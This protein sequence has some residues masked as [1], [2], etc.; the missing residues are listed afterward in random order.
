MQHYLVVIGTILVCVVA[1]VVNY[2]LSIENSPSEEVGQPVAESRV[3]ITNPHT[4]SDGDGLLNWE[5]DLHG[6]SKRH[7]DSDG[8]GIA[9]GVEVNNGTDPTRIEVQQEPEH[10]QIIT[11]PLETYEFAQITQPV[12]LQDLMHSYTH[13]PQ[14]LADLVLDNPALSAQEV[15]YKEGLNQIATLFENTQVSSLLD[16]Q[17]MTAYAQGNSVD[18]FPIEELQQAYQVAARGYQSI[19]ENYQEPVGGYARRLFELAQIAHTQLGRSLEYQANEE[20]Q[21]L[22]NNPW[23]VYAESQEA[24]VALL[25]EIHEWV[26]GIGLPFDHREPGYFFLFTL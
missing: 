4:D 17:I 15:H 8:D 24:L 18:R 11:E 2:L 21:E 6:T 1:L 20:A 13:D 14:Q 9:D 22:S 26:L 19:A 5:E 7:T 25:V 12:S 3:D 10:L 16:L 23:Q